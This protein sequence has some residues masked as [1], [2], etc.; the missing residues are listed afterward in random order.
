LSKNGLE[1]R[2]DQLEFVRGAD[3]AHATAA[4][5][6]Q[7]GQIEEIV[8]AWVRLMSVSI[9]VGINNSRCKHLPTS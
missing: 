8:R 6:A 1:G 5:L 2:P 9:G 4:R 3:R 7:L